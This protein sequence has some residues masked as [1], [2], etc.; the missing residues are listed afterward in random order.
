MYAKAIFNGAQID[1]QID[2]HYMQKK[3]EKILKI[4]PNPVF[5]SRTNVEKS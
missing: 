5:E 4:L 1:A 2:Q 3:I